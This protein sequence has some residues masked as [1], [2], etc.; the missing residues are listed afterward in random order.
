MNKR[1]PGFSLIEMLVAIALVVV[2]TTVAIP[3]FSSMLTNTRMA[4]ELNTLLSALNLA[5][6]EASKRGL[7]VSV[8]PMSGTACAN[9]TD[10]TA[11]WQVIQ[12]DTNTQINIAPALA[13]GETL[14]STVNTYPV[15]TAFGYTSFNGTLSIH[16]RNNTPSLYRC[17]VFNAGSWSAQQGAS[18]P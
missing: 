6:S 7:R 10:W 17:I 15:F 12:P 14:V 8:C 2:L 18:C 11:G 9:T 4:G 5:R 3:S 1:S 16:D 13:H